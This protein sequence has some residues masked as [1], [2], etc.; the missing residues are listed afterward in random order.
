MFNL[1]SNELRDNLNCTDIDNISF[2]SHSNSAALKEKNFYDKN[3]N[4]LK[5]KLLKSLDI[6]SK[7][8]NLYIKKILPEENKKT[9]IIDDYIEK[10][11]NEKS[12]KDRNEELLSKNNKII[13][14]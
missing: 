1:L 4:I 2:Q 7:N 8:H 14:Q 5:E 12:E 10:S 13:V 11:I 9:K 6:Q 3:K